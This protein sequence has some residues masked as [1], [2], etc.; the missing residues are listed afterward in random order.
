LIS[1][2]VLILRAVFHCFPIAHSRKG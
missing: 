2:T 1:T